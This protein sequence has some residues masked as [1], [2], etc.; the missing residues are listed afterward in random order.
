M[1]L[2]TYGSSIYHNVGLCVF[3]RVLS[4]IFFLIFVIKMSFL[5]VYITMY[6]YDDF[7]SYIYVSLY[8]FQV[9]PHSKRNLLHRFFFACG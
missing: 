5:V 2:H 1:D 4:D 7:K 6:V 9:T 3:H 8:A